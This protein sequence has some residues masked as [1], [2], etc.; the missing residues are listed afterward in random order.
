MFNLFFSSFNLDLMCSTPSC[1][2]VYNEVDLNMV[3]MWRFKSLMIWNI[4]AAFVKFGGTESW[5]SSLLKIVNLVNNTV[6][7][8][9]YSEN[10]T[11]KRLCYKQ[12]EIGLWSH[13]KR[14]LFGFMEKRCKTQFVY[15]RFYEY[16]LSCH[17]L[18]LTD[19]RAR[20]Y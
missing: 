15:W 6:A 18:F 1:K 3:L 11:Q 7:R 20:D 2:K 16:P 12:S 19:F 8:F 5:P 13:V 10:M 17:I 9:V 14:W 4:F